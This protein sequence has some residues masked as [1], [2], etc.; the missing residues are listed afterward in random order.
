MGSEGSVVD[1]STSSLKEVRASGKNGDGCG[2]RA[3]WP[4]RR[5]RQWET[6]TSHWL[7]SGCAC[8]GGSGGSLTTLH[9]SLPITRDARTKLRSRAERVTSCR[10][11][12]E[13]SGVGSS[14][15][16]MASVTPVKIQCS[17]PN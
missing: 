2:E 14:C 5:A 13:K 11:R 6:V 12:R 8:D 15:Q 9:C 16:A 4:C 10:N 17:S 1:P 7:Q 3:E